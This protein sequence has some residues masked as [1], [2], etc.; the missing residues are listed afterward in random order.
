VH[1][2]TDVGIAITSTNATLDRVWLHHHRRAVFAQARLRDTDVRITG[3]LIEDN[4]LIGIDVAGSK[5]LIDRSVLRSS[6]PKGSDEAAVGVLAQYNGFNESGADVTVRRSVVEKI[7]GV[8][9]DAIG[10]KLTLEDVLVRDTL[11]SASGQGGIGVLAD[12]ETLRKVKSTLTMTRTIVERARAT[13]IALS[14]ATATIDQCTVRTVTGT[15]RGAI[16]GFG[17]TALDGSILTLTKSLVRDT[18]TAAVAVTEG[19]L[20]IEGCIIRD[21]REQVSDGASGL[22]VLAAI[23]PKTRF[24]PTVDIVGSLVMNNRGAGILLQGARGSITGCVVRN[25]EPQKVDGRFGDGIYVSAFSSGGDVI[26]GDVA[27]EGTVVEKSAR[28][29]VIVAGA[30][31]KLSGSL[32]LCSKFD[33]EAGGWFETSAAGEKLTND[34]ALEDQGGNG[35]GCGVETHACRAQSSGL[36]PVAPPRVR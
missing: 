30:S 1:G 8:A 28:A 7:G 3:S 34:V 32:L 19:T 6:T 4:D 12:E 15:E 11:P 26:A 31:M 16:G 23:D 5:A 20:R 36:E 22:G 2:T 35:C 24:V 33:V 17:V 21:T 9:V 10:S 29:A 18:R 14:G 13:G 25:T 27:I